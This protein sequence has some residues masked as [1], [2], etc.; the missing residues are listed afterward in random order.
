MARHSRAAAT[1]QDHHHDRPT[2]RGA[3]RRRSGSAFLLPCSPFRTNRGDRYS[4]WWGRKGT[5]SLACRSQF[6]RAW[7]E[8]TIC[9]APAELP[10]FSCDGTQRHGERDGTRRDETRLD[11]RPGRAVP[12]HCRPSFPWGS[13]GAPGRTRQASARG[14]KYR[15]NES[16]HLVAMAVRLVCFGLGL[17]IGA[18]MAQYGKEGGRGG[19][20]RCSAGIAKLLMLILTSS[21]C[22]W[23]PVAVCNSS[24]AGTRPGFLHPRIKLLFLVRMGQQSVQPFY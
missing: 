22:S 19:K 1:A 5:G 2:E 4:P 13:A 18:A 15:S 16:L 14:P 7:R 8:H 10:G 11:E 17:M 9:R 3:E 20:S 24:D 21:Q 6:A 23:I 12:S